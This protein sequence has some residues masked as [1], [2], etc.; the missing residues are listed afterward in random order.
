M[1]SFCAFLLVFL[2]LYSPTLGFADA[3]EPMPEWLQKKKYQFSTNWFRQEKADLWTQRLKHLIHKPKVKYLEVGVFE[4]RSLLWA[5]DHIFTHPTAKAIAVDASS[6]EG[7]AVLREN[8]KKSG[9]KNKIKIMRERSETALR[10][11][12][13][14]SFDVI[15]IDGAH[16]VRTVLIDAVNAWY[17][18]KVGG[19]LI[20]DDY[21]M[22]ADTFP[23]DLRPQAAID[24][25]LLGFA[26]EFEAIPNSKIQ[27]IVKKKSEPV[28]FCHSCSWFGNYRY[29]W[30]R[31]VLTKGRESYTLNEDQKKQMQPILRELH[32]KRENPEVL[33]RALDLAEK[34]SM[35]LEQPND[36]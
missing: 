7:Q 10:K 6:I 22:H 12:P 20:F 31:G 5:M 36:L 23:L 2:N 25:F 3:A 11:L 14:E 21:L 16:N 27:V 15:Y 24:T 19:T 13:A 34:F 28:P 29:E 32:F 1:K 26:N 9:H 18:L 33:G 30:Y 17:L 8:I 4:G 35:P